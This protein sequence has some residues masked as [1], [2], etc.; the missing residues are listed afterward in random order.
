MSI[1]KHTHKLQPDSPAVSRSLEKAVAW[2]NALSGFL[3]SLIEAN[4]KIPDALQRRV[5][6]S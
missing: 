6:S 3:E 5:L 1:Y 2:V 4:K